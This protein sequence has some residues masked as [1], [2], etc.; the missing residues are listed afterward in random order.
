MRKVEE[1][2]MPLTQ[3]ESMALEKP[4]EDYNRARSA[5]RFGAGVLL[6]ASAVVGIDTIANHDTGPGPVSLVAAPIAGAM[7]SMTLR[8]RGN[9]LKALDDARSVIEVS[10]SDLPIVRHY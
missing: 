3:R 10:P 2:P 5:K 4:F 9:Q 6:L 8:E 1:F 7:A